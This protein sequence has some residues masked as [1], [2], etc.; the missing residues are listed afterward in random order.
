[1][2]SE[3][4]TER[5]KSDASSRSVRLDFPE[6]KCKCLLQALLLNV[7]T[8]MFTDMVYNC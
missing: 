4:G 2:F 6:D 5:E 7:N 1:M 8:Q 3:Q